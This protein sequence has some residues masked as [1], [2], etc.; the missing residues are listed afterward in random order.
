MCR[1]RSACINITLK[2][3]GKKDCVYDGSDEEC[4]HGKY[5]T[6]FPTCFLACSLLTFVYDHTKSHD[7]VWKISAFILNHDFI[8]RLF[9]LAQNV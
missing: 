1:D 8:L 2:C 6:R 7:I 5:S 9:H 3:D 4:A